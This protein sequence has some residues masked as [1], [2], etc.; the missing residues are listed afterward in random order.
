M[1]VEKFFVDVFQVVM[2]KGVSKLAYFINLIFVDEKIEDV[3]WL[4]FFTIRYNSRVLMS[5]FSKIENDLY[6]KKKPLVKIYLMKSVDIF[7]T[8]CGIRVFNAAQAVCDVV[9]HVCQRISRKADAFVFL[10]GSETP[11][12][13]K[14]LAERCVLLVNDN[15]KLRKLALH[16]MICL[17]SSG[18]VP[19][20]I[21]TLL[22]TD[23]Y[24][25]IFSV[26]GDSELCSV[27]GSAALLLLTLLLGCRRSTELNSLL[28][29][30][31]AECNDSSLTGYESVIGK[32]LTDCVNV[33]RDIVAYGTQSLF[34]SFV[35]TMSN[36]LALNEEKL[37][38][39]FGCKNEE[40]ENLLAVYYAVRWNQKAPSVLTSVR[41]SISS[42]S[43]EADSSYEMSPLS[44]L[45]TYCS[46]V[47]HDT[48]SEYAKRRCEL[49]LL[50]LLCVVEDVQALNAMHDSNILLSV[51]LYRPP[52]LH[53]Y[54]EFI[55]RP[56]PTTMASALCDLVYEFI[57]SHMCISFPFQLYEL[58]IGVVHRM[59][60]FEKR[61]SFRM[62]KWKPIF[63]ALVSLLNFLTSNETHLG[64]AIYPICLRVMVLLNLFI[65][66]GDTFLPN[67]VA[68]DHM[69]YEIIRQEAVF[70][71]LLKSAAKLREN[72]EDVEEHLRIATK[73][74]SQL[75]NPLEIINHFKDKLA[76]LHTT[77]FSEEEVLEVV[78]TNFDSLHLK[79]YEGLETA[80][81]YD[82]NSVNTL[83]DGL[84]AVVKKNSLERYGLRNFDFSDML[85]TLSFID[86]QKSSPS[87]DL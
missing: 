35:S 38:F 55:E 17:M 57:M 68:Y 74:I 40:V 15:F 7:S 69:C 12:T 76:Q 3:D 28:E 53:R 67:D 45:L 63:E 22:L 5:T 26:I 21:D 30:F 41:Q 64:V 60:A 33:Y 32:W 23:I 79:L 82:H 77:N 34:E 36:F 46:F 51:P 9:E 48:K 85:H 80:E 27:D 6:T 56:L 65:T 14:R 18:H 50:I 54:G 11:A 10:L 8:E 73:V 37:S 81:P 13:I 24:E 49:C 20:L 71:K 70:R 25:S 87:V 86:S 47:V 84:I 59:V 72:S 75:E 39:E 62:A 66:Y 61:M 16:L 44:S 29:K 58:V 4:Q 43:E 42:S 83:L 52:M 78:R 1:F 31:S 2:E 19:S